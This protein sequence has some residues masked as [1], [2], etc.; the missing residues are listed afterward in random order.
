MISIERPQRTK[1]MEPLA[2]SDFLPRIRIASSE[3]SRLLEAFLDAFLDTQTKA[4]NR[5][6]TI[7]KL[8]PTVTSGAVD[9]FELVVGSGSP[10]S[11]NRSSCLSGARKGMAVNLDRVIVG[12]SVSPD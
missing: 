6:R 12:W 5:P 2:P 11:P 10:R 7:A 1:A 8:D 3:I 9:D 4:A